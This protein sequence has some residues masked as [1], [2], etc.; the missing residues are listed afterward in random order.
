MLQIIPVPEFIDPVFRKTSPKRSFSVMQNE[1]IGLVFPKT[2]SINSDTGHF[3][4]IFRKKDFRE[5]KRKKPL[6]FLHLINKFLQCC[7][8]GNFFIPDPRSML[9][10]IP[11]SR[12]VSASE[13]TSKN[14]S[15]FSSRKNDLG[16]SFQIRMFFPS[17]IHGSKITLIF[18]LK[19][20]S[21]GKR[22]LS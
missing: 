5:E 9:K 3:S 2:W 19:R 4:T 10:T 22:C 6:T 8:S 18:C 20:I 11:E 12:S 7:G 16:C 15:I 17:R 1:R 21:I 13:S 14:L